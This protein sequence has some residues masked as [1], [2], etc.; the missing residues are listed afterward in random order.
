MF[1]FFSPVALEVGRL[2]DARRCNERSA[3]AVLA[4]DD[5]R[6]TTAVELV[7]TVASLVARDTAELSS[8]EDRWDEATTQFSADRVVAEPLAIR[9]LAELVMRDITRRSAAP[10]KDSLAADVSALAERVEAFDDALMTHMDC[11]S[12]L[13]DGDLLPAWRRLLLSDTD[14]PLP[15]WLD[16]SLELA[17]AAR[18]NELDDVA[19]HVETAIGDGPSSPNLNAVSDEGL[20]DRSGGPGTASDVAPGMPY[21]WH[22]PTRNLIATLEVPARLDEDA[23]LRLVFSGSDRESVR[24][25]VG[26]AFLL[27]GFPVI[28]CRWVDE[29]AGRAE[30]SVTALA[31]ADMRFAD[32]VLESAGGD[33][34]LPHA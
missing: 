2:L 24:E 22:H 15:W 20:T 19:R 16:G 32:A 31:V 21:R 14:E 12:T 23:Q 25:L 1:L 34:W 13:A 10:S 9:L 27:N 18:A 3:L 11:L 5:S 8:L 29:D 4:D 28:V 7:P 17:A 33:R 30:A 26:E 6:T